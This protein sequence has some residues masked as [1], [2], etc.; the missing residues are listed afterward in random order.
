M[1]V[2]SNVPVLLLPF[3][4]VIEIISHL[5]KIFS[6]AIRLFANM[7]S[8]HVLLHIL[9]GFVLDLAKKNFLFIIFPTILIMSIVLLEYG[10]TLLQAYVFATLLAIYFEEHFGFSQEDNNKISKLILI[11][12]QKISCV[13]QMFL[14][15]LYILTLKR[16]KS[17]YF[18][19]I[20]RYQ[21]QISRIRRQKYWSYTL[22][23]KIFLK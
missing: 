6:L 8:G 7:M 11:N 12:G 4:I 13:K 10:I 18:V 9:T 3:L 23:R 14:L 20:D 1:F 5:A 19:F 22:L 2:P 16:K 17:S 15:R 21:R